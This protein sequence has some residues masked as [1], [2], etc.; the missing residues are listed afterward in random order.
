MEFKPEVSIIVT[1]HN[2]E[3]YIEKCIKSA[4]NQTYTNVEIIC[5]D[6]G[7]KDNTPAILKDLQMRDSRIVLISDSNT[8]YGH[9]VNVGINTA[10][11]SYIC[12]LESDDCLP[13]DMVEKLYT[14][15]KETGVDVVSGDYKVSFEIDNT[16][17]GFIRNKYSDQNYDRICNFDLEDRQFLFGGITGALYKKRFLIDNKIVLNETPGASFQDQSFSFLVDLL[18]TKQYHIKTPA[19]IYTYDN[20]DSSMVDDKKVL[21]ITWECAYIERQLRERNVKQAKIWDTFFNYKY[22]TYI[23]KLKSFND[24]GKQIFKE[25]LLKELHEDEVKVEYILCNFSE[26]VSADIAMIKEDI[27]CF[28][29]L[30]PLPR[31]ANRMYRV[32]RMLDKEKLFMVGAGKNG[33]ALVQVAND[34]KHSFLGVCDNSEALHGKNIYGYTIISLK[35]AVEENKNCKFIVT[36]EQY[37]TQIKNQLL[38]Y[39]V[40]ETNIIFY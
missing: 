14:I 8:S 17:V 21:E 3:R 19:Y 4:L 22:S 2:A 38:S 11:G 30:K 10:K 34:Y 28:D 9:K 39:C 35:Q 36:S 24:E 18:S 7:S 5:V 25:V 26:K 29:E 37:Y 12:I 33:Q 40:S 23:S 32:L 27:N 6:G 13:V 20:P 31:P 16:Q 15:A 1:V